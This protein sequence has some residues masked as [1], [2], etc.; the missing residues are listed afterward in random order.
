MRKEHSTGLPNR[1]LLTRPPHSPS[2]ARRR[3]T[4]GTQR[5]E[6]LLQEM[7]SAQA[8]PQRSRSRQRRSKDQEGATRP[9]DHEDEAGARLPAGA[10]E[11]ES[12]TERRGQRGER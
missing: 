5:R 3:H 1:T 8:P 7:H 6:S 9:R 2:Q 12:G 10:A 11:Q 4:A